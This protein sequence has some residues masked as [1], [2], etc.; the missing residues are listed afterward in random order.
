MEQFNY[1]P[2]SSGGL[3]PPQQSIIQT[4]NDDLY[5]TWCCGGQRPPLLYNQ[6]SEMTK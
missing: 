3:R 6:K 2:I 1:E 4:I 5:S